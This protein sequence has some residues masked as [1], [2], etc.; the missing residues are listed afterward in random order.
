[1][2]KRYRLMNSAPNPFEPPRSSTTYA[3]ESPK[4]EKASISPRGFLV[5]AACSFSMWALSPILTGRVEPWDSGW[6]FLATL[7][8]GFAVG[9]VDK[10]PS[11][12]LRSLIGLFPFLGFWFGQLSYVWIWRRGMGPLWLIVVALF[13]YSIPFLPTYFLTTGIQRLSKFRS[14][15]K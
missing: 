13:I 4:I 8:S 10:Q 14:S 3:F 1:M 6:Y 5:S 9:F 7:G 12:F 11:G 2:R 15:S